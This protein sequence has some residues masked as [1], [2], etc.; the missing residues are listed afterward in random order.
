MKKEVKNKNERVITDYNKI[1]M[2]DDYNYYSITRIIINK[3]HK[4]HKS[5]T[6]ADTN[7]Y[8]GYSDGDDSYIGVLTTNKAEFDKVAKD[9]NILES[10]KP[11]LKK[12][13]YDFSVKDL[14]TLNKNRDFANFL[15]KYNFTLKLHFDED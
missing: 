14:Y 4:K 10:E 11:Y 5:L 9:F 15:V 12:Y 13:M 1:D 2:I 8:F 7:K 3:R 6:L